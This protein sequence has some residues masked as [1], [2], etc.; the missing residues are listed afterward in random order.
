MVQLEELK[1]LKTPA[2]HHLY[3][4]AAV[5]VVV[6]AYVASAAANFATAATYRWTNNNKINPSEEPQGK[7][8]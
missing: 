2:T 4:V 1:T 3:I 6:A 8:A 5:F 7:R